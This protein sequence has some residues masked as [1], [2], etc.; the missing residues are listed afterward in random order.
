VTLLGEFQ[1]LGI[2]FV[3]LN[4][5]IDATTLAGR[6]QMHI[7]AAIAEFEGVQN[8]RTG[9]GRPAAGRAQGKR[10]GRPRQAVPTVRV[11]AV[12]DLSLI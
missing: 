3:S 2:A 12:L 9:Q 4:E 6:L 11:E 8:R 5:G 7:S 10:I 1:A